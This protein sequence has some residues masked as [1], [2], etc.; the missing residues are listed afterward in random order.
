MWK[1]GYETAFQ[2]CKENFKDYRTD[3]RII[4]WN[5]DSTNQFNDQF[6]LYSFKELFWPTRWCRSPL[7]CY[8]ISRKSTWSL[9]KS[10]VFPHSH[11]MLGLTMTEAT[12]TAKVCGCECGYVCLCWGIIM[13]ARVY[14]V[15]GPARFTFYLYV[16][17]KSPAVQTNGK[18]P[19]FFCWK[20]DLPLNGKTLN[21]AFLSRHFLLT[22][23]R[24]REIWWQN[25]SKANVGEPQ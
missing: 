13:G 3:E 5:T 10:W 21:I 6:I 1:L 24:K 19:G 11:T 8:A 23:N 14:V 15:C 25:L 18:N 7:F 17:F 9:L 2:L 4:H 16:G 12:A 20:T 22:R